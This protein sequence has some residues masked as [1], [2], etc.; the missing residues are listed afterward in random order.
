MRE[1]EAPIICSSRKWADRI[2][3]MDIYANMTTLYVAEITFKSHSRSSEVARFD[4]DYP[5]PSLTLA[6]LYNSFLPLQASRSIY[7]A[8]LSGSS[9]YIPAFS[10][11]LPS[12]I[13]ST[14]IKKQPWRSPSSDSTVHKKSTLQMAFADQAVVSGGAALGLIK[15]RGRSD[16]PMSGPLYVRPLAL[17]SSEATSQH[18]GK[19]TR[20]CGDSEQACKSAAGFSDEDE[21]VL[22]GKISGRPT[23]L[24]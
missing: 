22:C 5:Y 3:E 14:S 20:V 23:F 24:P 6:N 8:L 4:R 7:P 15:L 16:E 13:Q 9:R 12:V 21:T 18:G 2:A 19:P 10:I 11:A 1:G 17:R